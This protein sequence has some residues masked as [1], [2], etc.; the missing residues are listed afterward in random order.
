MDFKIFAKCPFYVSLN[1]LKFLYLLWGAFVYI[2]H[3]PAV[4]LHELGAVW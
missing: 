2:P 1:E 4:C 3:V